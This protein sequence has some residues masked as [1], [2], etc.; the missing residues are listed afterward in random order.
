MTLTKYDNIFIK[1]FPVKDYIDHIIIKLHGDQA[2]INS[3]CYDYEYEVICCLIDLYPEYLLTYHDKTCRNVLITTLETCDRINVIY[4]ILE[5]FDCNKRYDQRMYALEYGLKLND[6]IPTE[7]IKYLIENINFD[8][9]VALAYALHLFD[10]DNKYLNTKYDY[11]L[12]LAHT[13]SGHH[14]RY[15][16]SYSLLNW[17]KKHDCVELLMAVIKENLCTL[18]LFDCHV[19]IT[20]ID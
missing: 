4:K 12:L 5:H 15:G 19:I 14:D 11:K 18:L 8:H 9:S 13:Y 10:Y 2:L 17:C 20:Y 16:F 7:I 3:I 1:G 6:Q